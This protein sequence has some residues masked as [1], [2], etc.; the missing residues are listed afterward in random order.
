LVPLVVLDRAM[1]GNDGKI[2]FVWERF[3]RW[4]WVGPVG[5]KDGF[6]ALPRTVWGGGDRQ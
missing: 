6:L 1:M 3:A 2:L 4:S 5:G